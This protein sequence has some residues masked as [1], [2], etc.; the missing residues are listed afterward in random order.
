MSFAPL[1]V[2]LLAVLSRMGTQRSVSLVPAAAR[3]LSPLAFPRV[4]QGRVPCICPGVLVG[5]SSTAISAR[6]LLSLWVLKANACD[7]GVPSETN[8]ATTPHSL[9]LSA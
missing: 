9:P 1:Q 2:H 7:L 8:R 4:P 5:E 6:A 3:L